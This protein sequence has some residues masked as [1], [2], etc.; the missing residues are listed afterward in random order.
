L[1]V[2]SFKSRLRIDAGISATDGGQTTPV[3]REPAMF[4]IG[5][6]IIIAVLMVLALPRIRR[7]R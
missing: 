2:F 3:W 5:L 1:L 7:A 4:L 6:A